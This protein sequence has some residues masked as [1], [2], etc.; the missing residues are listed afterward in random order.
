MAALR[1]YVSPG[2]TLVL[3]GPSGVGKSTLA[4]M[5]IGADILGVGA[6]RPDGKGRHVTAARD[7]VP[8]PSGGVLI[9]TPACAGSASLTSRGTRADVSRDRSTVGRLPVR[10]LHACGRAGMCRPGRRRRG[11]TAGPP[12]G[13]LA[14]AAA[15]GA[16]HGA[17][18]MPGC[19]LPSFAGGRPSRV[20][21]GVRASADHEKP[22]V[23]KT[24]RRSTVHSSGPHPRARCAWRSMW[25][26]WTVPTRG[27]GSPR[28]CAHIRYPTRWCSHCHE[29][30]CPSGSV[31]RALH[32]DFD[33]FVARKVG[34]PGRSEL[35]VGAIAEAREPARRCAR[36]ADRLARPRAAASPRPRRADVAEIVAAE[37]E[38]LRRRI[39]SI[40]AR[41]RRNPSPG[42]PSS[43]S[44]TGSRPAAPSA[45]RCARCGRREPR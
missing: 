37:K 3:I 44:T 42:G 6:T 16:P 17:A 36:G 5:L 25:S 1:P 27:V 20:P 8:L 45:R 22:C 10:R 9:D 19:V 40:A 43:L 14:Q 41:G 39:G 21:S 26:S 4:N 30:A 12:P 15:R 28:W 31:A 13:E 23:R 2:R 29:V 33:V 7:L 35:G 11:N 18:P 34:A 38:E 32:A 24:D